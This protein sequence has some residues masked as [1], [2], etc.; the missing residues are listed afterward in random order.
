MKLRIQA[1]QFQPGDIIVGKHK[2]KNIIITNDVEVYFNLGNPLV[3][4]KYTMI[5]VERAD[6]P[7]TSLS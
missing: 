6:A 3:C 4:S 1:Q 2:I 5:N 7:T